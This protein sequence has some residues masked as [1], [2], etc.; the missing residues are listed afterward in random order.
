MMNQVVLH[1]QAAHVAETASSEYGGSKATWIKDMLQTQLPQ[2]F[3]T[4]K[5]QVTSIA[6]CLPSLPPPL[7]TWERGG[8]AAV[9][10]QRIGPPL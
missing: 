9:R 2:Q 7:P 3:P 8:A 1:R 4:I 5:A 6:P 10:D